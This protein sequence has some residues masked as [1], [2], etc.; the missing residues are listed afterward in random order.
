MVS[1]YAKPT[2][3]AEFGTGAAGAPALADPTGIA[4]HNGIWASLTGRA[5]MTAMSW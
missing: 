4:L 5:A 2:F 1:E 3:I